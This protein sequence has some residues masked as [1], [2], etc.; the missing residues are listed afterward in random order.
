MAAHAVSST[1]RRVAACL[2]AQ[3]R[4][5]H[6]LGRPGDGGVGQRPGAALPP[7]L[8]RLLELLEETGAQGLQLRRRLHRDPRLA[9][10][11]DVRHAAHARQLVDRLRHGV[12]RLQAGQV[13][14]RL[15]HLRVETDAGGAQQEEGEREGW[16]QR[17]KP[18]LGCRI[19]QRLD[20]VACV[21]LWTRGRA[22]VRARR[23]VACAAR[24]DK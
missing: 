6:P 16:R 4:A 15:A 13:D 18:G 5:M 19:G 24:D 3:S 21:R 22:C 14:Q 23:W 11:G 20:V 1:V 10:D 2:L 12:V 17:L 8:L 9:V 7:L